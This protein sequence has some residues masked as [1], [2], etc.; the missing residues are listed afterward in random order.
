MSEVSKSEPKSSGRMPSMQRSISIHNN[1]RSGVS[2][3]GLNEAGPNDADRATTEVPNSKPKY[4]P[5]ATERAARN[6]CQRVA[7]SG[8]KRVDRPVS[9]S[10]FRTETRPKY[11]L[12]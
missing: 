1:R 3:P 12:K 9:G 8:H 6:E 11:S 2:A 4:E 5:T 7:R 10:R